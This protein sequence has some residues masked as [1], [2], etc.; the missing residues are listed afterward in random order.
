MWTTTNTTTTSR[1]TRLYINFHTIAHLPN[2]QNGSI[3]AGFLKTYNMYRARGFRVM[4]CR[5]TMISPLFATT[6]SVWES[7]SI[8]P[9]ETN[10]C[11][12]SSATSAPSESA[13][14]A[15]STRSRLSLSHHVWSPKWSPRLSSGST[16]FHLRK[17]GPPP[18][19]RVS[20]CWANTLTTRS[21]V[22]WHSEP[23]FRLMTSMITP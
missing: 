9:Q 10:M 3:M 15:S 8:P 12:K 14:V 23:T 21:I 22:L 13:V 4:H 2:K 5:G 18:S 6:S 20:W 1:N 11:P 16:V 7:N 17:E 19:V